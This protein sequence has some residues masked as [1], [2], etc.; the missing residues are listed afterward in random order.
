ML[1]GLPPDALPS[2]SRRI[3]APVAGQTTYDMKCG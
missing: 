1:P 3:I 2:S